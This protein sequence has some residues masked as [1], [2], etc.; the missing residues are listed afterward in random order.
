MGTGSI[1]CVVI[2]LGMADRQSKWAR[3]CGMLLIAS[4]RWVAFRLDQ[5]EDE[6]AFCGWYVLPQDLVS[7]AFPSA[8]HKELEFMSR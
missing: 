3:L 6:T 1:L 8:P 4:I 5:F 7:D 2:V